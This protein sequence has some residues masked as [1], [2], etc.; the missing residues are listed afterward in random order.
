MHIYLLVFIKSMLLLC[1]SFKIL[2]NLKF[3]KFMYILG[4]SL[5]INSSLK[6]HQ[7]LLFNY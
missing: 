3:N 6:N 1:K 5:F 7:F 2:G 4:M